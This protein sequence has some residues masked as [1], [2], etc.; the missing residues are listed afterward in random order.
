LHEGLGPVDSGIRDAIDAVEASLDELRGNDDIGHRL[1]AE[2]LDALVAHLDGRRRLA[3]NAG[4]LETWLHEWAQ[5]Q[6]P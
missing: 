1:G 6:Q 3:A 2:G 4:G 5:A